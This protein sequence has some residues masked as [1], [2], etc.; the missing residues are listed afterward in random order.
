MM[1]LML[2]G[3]TYCQYP[4]T[5]V[6]N[7]DTIV[8]LEKKQA[9]DINNRFL[10]FQN[11]IDSQKNLLSKKVDTPLNLSD[12]YE[13]NRKLYA[14]YKDAERLA[15]YFTCYTKREFIKKYKVIKKLLDTN[16]HR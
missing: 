6:I 4:K 9:D 13:T 7:G 1:G 2:A 3:Q 16:E 8:L 5:R 12:C 15:F 11:I 10:I 14:Y